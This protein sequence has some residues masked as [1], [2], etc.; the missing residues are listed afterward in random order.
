MAS[1]FWFQMSIENKIIARLFDCFLYEV[2]DQKT[3]PNGQ[4]FLK[5]S[6]MKAN[7]LSN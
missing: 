4:L 1:G 7:F 2:R 5:R 6:L 3:P